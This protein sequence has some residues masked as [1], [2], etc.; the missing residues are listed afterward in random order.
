MN[1]QL[2]F[3]V[4]CLENFKSYKNLTGKQV[5]K[6]FRE[7]GVFDHL[8]EFYDVLHTQGHQ[9]INHDIEDFLLARHVSIPT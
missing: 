1:K 3:S 2:A 8:E 5:Y 9:Y 7:H 4:F 6:L